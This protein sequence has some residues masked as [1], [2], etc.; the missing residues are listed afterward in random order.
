MG[1]DEIYQ[2][3][4]ILLNCICRPVRKYL[5]SVSI[6]FFP[7]DFLECYWTIFYLRVCFCPLALCSH[8][9]FFTIVLTNYNDPLL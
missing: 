6:F 1:G 8:G 7:A 3:S 2:L 9:S 5:E 4:G